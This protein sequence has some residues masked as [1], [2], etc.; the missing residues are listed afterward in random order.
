[1]YAPAVVTVQANFILFGAAVEPV[2]GQ[3]FI[4]DA[5]PLGANGRADIIRVANGTRLSNGDI[6]CPFSVVFAPASLSSAL[7]IWPLQTGETLNRPLGPGENDATSG[8]LQNAYYPASNIQVTVNDVNGSGCAYVYGASIV[9]GDGLSDV[10]I[11]RIHKRCHES[12]APE[13]GACHPFIPWGDSREARD[14][15]TVYLLGDYIANPLDVRAQNA[16][17]AI[18]RGVIS[19][20]RYVEY[21]GYG[22][23][24]GLLISTPAYAVSAGMPIISGQGELLGM[25]T[26]SL[27]AIVPRI[28][29]S[30]LVYAPAL[31]QQSGSGQVAGPSS[32]H[33]RPIIS[34]L[35]HSEQ[36]RCHDDRSVTRIAGN[37][38]NFGIYRKGYLGLAYRVA[39]SVALTTVTDYTSGVAPLGQP[40]FRLS[41][42]GFDNV[43]QPK[44]AGLQVQGLAGLNPAGTAGQVDG[45]YFVPGGPASGIFP[46]LPESPLLGKVRPGDLLISASPL[47]VIDGKRDINVLGDLKNQVAL[48]L[49]TRD[50]FPGDEIEFCVLRGG[51]VLNSVPTATGGWYVN[52]AT[53]SAVLAEF[54][55]LLDYP[56]AAINDWPQLLTEVVA[57]T[58]YPSF[59]VPAGQQT[60]PQLPALIAPGSGVFHPAL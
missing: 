39:T 15:Q 42:G 6:M 59:T 21:S 3:P 17:G 1:M 56:W 8:S 22:L 52:R 50:A 34:A 57:P 14:G 49:I 51:N 5:T 47:R 33:L 24:E 31:N 25:Q 48:S 53:V 40:R 38:G 10:A 27:A 32:F 44:V 35:I 58:H 54:P 7:K 26:S 13:I 41:S 60:N 46:A 55:P 9:G 20:H 30:S 28:D 29:P 11:L 45:Y 19:D 12:C 43:Y 23:A 16:S 18:A 2:E 37:R 36:E 4:N